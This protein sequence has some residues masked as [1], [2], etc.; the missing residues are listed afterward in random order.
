MWSPAS[1]FAI[2][3]GARALAA[4]WRVRRPAFP[5]AGPCV[6]AFWH[7]ELFPTI[8]L[9]RDA[10]VT[11]MASLSRDGELLARVL[12]HLDVP[13]I[14]GSSSRGGPEVVAA[15]ERVLRAGGRV[16]VAVDGPR[17]PAGVP[18]RG[19]P[20]LAQACGVPVVWVRARGWGWRARSWDR[21]SVPAPLARVHVSYRTWAPGEGEFAAFVGDQP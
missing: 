12:A 13:T 15:A 10:S 18:K 1:T 21:F 19:A 5:V 6:V 20:R 9:H 3:L 4:T 11:M 8:L 16:A 14:R 7:G 2:A 17:G